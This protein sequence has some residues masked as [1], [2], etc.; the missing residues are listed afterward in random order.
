M[1]SLQRRRERYAAIYVWKIL[2][3]MV[4]NLSPPIAENLSGRRGRMCV[5]NVV[6]RGHIGSLAYNSFR[7]R[8]SRIFNALPPGVRNMSKCGVNVFKRKLDNFLSQVPDDPCETNSDN[9][10]AGAALRQSWCLQRDGLAD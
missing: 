7:W 1:Y 3:D 8:G 5:L 10:I 6:E 4:P 2:E 9:S